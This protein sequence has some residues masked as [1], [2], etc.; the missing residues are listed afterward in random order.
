MP[1]GYKHTK[2]A[3][4]K[5]RNTLK[6]HIVTKITREKISKTKMG[7]KR[8][9]ESRLKQGRT[10]K[11][12]KRKPFTKEHCEKLAKAHTGR[13]SYFYID[14]RSS[15]IYYCIDCRKEI[16]R[17]SWVYGNKR[18]PVCAG[19]E[20]W[21]DSEFVRKQ[22]NSRGVRPTKPEKLLNKILRKILL[23]EYKYV[24]DGEVILG[25]LCPDFININGQKK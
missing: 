24:G 7:H 3:C 15:N 8:T 18:C 5:I 22:M 12:R 17:W 4:E 2:E 25:G 9:I 14:G 13:K 6:G 10:L 21:K 1:K 19:K 11:G 16:S 23:N 20:K